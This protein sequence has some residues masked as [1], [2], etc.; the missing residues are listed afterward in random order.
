MELFE[1]FNQVG[2]TVVIAT[3]DIDL[4]NNFG[5]RV[6]ALKGGEVFQDGMLS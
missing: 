4:L 1:R 3:H 6:V 5:H 2:V